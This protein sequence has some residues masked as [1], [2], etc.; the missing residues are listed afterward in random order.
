[1]PGYRKQSTARNL[2]NRS[3]LV[4]TWES[5]T[6]VLLPTFL[7]YVEPD[8]QTHRSALNKVQQLLV[9]LEP[10]FQ[11]THRSA[12]NKFQQ[13]LVVLMKLRLN[14]SNQYLA[15]SFNVSDT[16]ISRVFQSVLEV[17]HVILKTS[18]SLTG[19]RWAEKTMP[20]SFRTHLELKWQW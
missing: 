6:T 1:M 5:S 9:V 7:Y 20:M 17:L 16:T 2:T 12:L 14:A 8:F 18:N 15:V 10:D 19:Q 4:M 3:S 13:L 11:T